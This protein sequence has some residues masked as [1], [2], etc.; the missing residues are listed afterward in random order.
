MKKD[1]KINLGCKSC[2]TLLENDWIDDSS[3]K[4]TQP[5]NKVTNIVGPKQKTK[6]S[7]K[8]VSLF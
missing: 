5:T 2:D 7:A 8:M 1:F 6:K 4:F 3:F